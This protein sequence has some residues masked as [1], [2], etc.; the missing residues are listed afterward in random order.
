MGDNGSA[1]EPYER[2]RTSQIE[3]KN[4]ACELHQRGSLVRSNP[5]V[6]TQDLGRLMTS[7]LLTIPSPTEP[8]AP[9]TEVDSADLMALI[10][11]DNDLVRADVFALQLRHV[12]DFI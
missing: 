6:T 3:P 1:G 12:P 4:G 2:C 10:V 9:L 7:R 11:P 8:P 5:H